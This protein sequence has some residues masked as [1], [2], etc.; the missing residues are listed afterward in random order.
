M[1][2]ETALG[3]QVFDI[4][5][6]ELDLGW[7][8]L[9]EFAAAARGTVRRARRSRAGWVGRDFTAPGAGMTAEGALGTQVF[10]STGRGPARGWL[11]LLKSAAASVLVLAAGP[12]AAGRTGR[13]PI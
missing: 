5:G 2:G 3:K 12:F 7:L 10:A 11:G 8:G 13:R 1:A 6:R 4:T 9:L